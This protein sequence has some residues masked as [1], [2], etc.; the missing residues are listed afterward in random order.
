M[1]ILNK[2]E[3]KAIAVDIFG[4]YPKANKV[5]VTDDGMAFITDESDLAVKNHSLKNPSGKELGIST[6]KRDELEAANDNRVESLLKRIA[7]AT[8]ADEVTAIRETEAKGKNRTTVIAAADK[9]LDE[10]KTE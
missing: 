2:G 8:T 3:L 4:R 9:R 10:L 7:D 1:T 5:S 6:F